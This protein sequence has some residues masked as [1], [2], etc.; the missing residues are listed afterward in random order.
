MGS[1]AGPGLSR[2]DNASGSWWAEPALH[3]MVMSNSASRTAQRYNLGSRSRLRNRLVSAE[4]S[5]NRVNGLPTKYGRKC[6]TAHS[7][8]MHSLSMAPLRASVANHRWLAWARTLF[9]PSFS[10]VTAAPAPEALASVC[11]TNGVS[12]MG[13][14]RMGNVVKADLRDRKVC[15]CCSDHGIRKRRARVDAKAYCEVRR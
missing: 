7:T 12:L 13:K 6:T 15:C 4:Q 1:A 8:A 9:K 3:R 2:R 10:C 5:V 11:S 14:G